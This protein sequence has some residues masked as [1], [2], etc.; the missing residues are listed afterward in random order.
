MR[1]TVP[2]R[3]GGLA[4]NEAVS[5]DFTYS[6]RCHLTGSDSGIEE[7][8]ESGFVVNEENGV[9]D[10]LDTSPLN[11]FFYCNNFGIEG[12]ASR[13]PAEE[14]L[15]R[16]VVIDRERVCAA[17]SFVPVSSVSVYDRPI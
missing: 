3:K 5:E 11:R 2:K 4:I 8:A 16:V 13:A 6:D 17:S 12:G 14:I 9:V 7:G 15:P 10:V 1:G